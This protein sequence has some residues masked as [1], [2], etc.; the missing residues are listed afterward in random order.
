[1]NKAS[2]I[3]RLVRDPE[4]KTTTSG[5]SVCKFSIAVKRN[6]KDAN[7]EYQSDFIDCVAW[8]VIGET[9]AKYTHKGNMLGVSGR[10]ESRKYEDRDG[11]NRSVL[12]LIVEDKDLLSP[13]SD[14]STSEGGGHKHQEEP[15]VPVDDDDLPF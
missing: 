2:F 7:G 1:M 14:S 13:K 3:G 4:L 10:M 12:E 15:P 6:Y 11:N 9:I 8:G 5:K